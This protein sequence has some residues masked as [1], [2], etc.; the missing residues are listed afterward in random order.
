MM[1]FM[2]HKGQPLE[3]PNITFNVRARG[4]SYLEWAQEVYKNDYLAQRWKWKEMQMQTEDGKEIPTAS[5]YAP[6][7]LNDRLEPKTDEDMEKDFPKYTKK[8]VEKVSPDGERSITRWLSPRPRELLLRA[9]T[10]SFLLELAFSDSS[11][12]GQAPR[13]SSVTL[14][15]RS[16]A[17]WS[18]VWST[19]RAGSCSLPDGAHAISSSATP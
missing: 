9:A 5:Q 12:C 3:K 2:K 17:T 10:F 4:K 15:S 8:L 1:K 14:C 11:R 7:G 16:S 18:R 6:T 13:A 19:L